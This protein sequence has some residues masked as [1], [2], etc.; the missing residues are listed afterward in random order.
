MIFPTDPK[1]MADRLIQKLTGNC[2]IEM[3]FTAP[4]SCMKEQTCFVRKMTENA[5]MRTSRTLGDPRV[6]GD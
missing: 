1:E 5:M 3:G 4:K 2:W 6:R